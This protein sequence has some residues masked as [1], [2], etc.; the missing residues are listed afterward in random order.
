MSTKETKYSLSTVKP[1]LTIANFLKCWRLC[2]EWSQAELASKIGMTA[3]NLCDIEKGRKG[4]SIAKACEIGEAL[5]YSP[6]VL[7]KLVLQEA[8]TAAGLN[9]EVELKKKR[10]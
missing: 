1:K 7:V 10:A 9:Y 2:E 4:V 3:A 8:V 5:G 6:T